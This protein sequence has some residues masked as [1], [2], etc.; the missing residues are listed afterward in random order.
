MRSVI[1]NHEPESNF[2]LA[3]Q[4]IKVTYAAYF[5]DEEGRRIDLK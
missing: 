4:V 3:S 1:S 2:E 5:S